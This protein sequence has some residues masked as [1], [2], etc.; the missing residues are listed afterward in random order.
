MINR[1]K[2]LLSQP[3]YSA[4]LDLAMAEL[5]DPPSQVRW[6]VREHLRQKGLLQEVSAGTQKIIAGTDNKEK[7]T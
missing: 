1:L 2:I 7:T 4:L 5:R 3:E 6:L